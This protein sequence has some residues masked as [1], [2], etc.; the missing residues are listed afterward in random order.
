MAT[1]ALSNR[2]A[3]KGPV[4]SHVAKAALKPSFNLGVVY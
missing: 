1:M 2:L 3:S 4:G